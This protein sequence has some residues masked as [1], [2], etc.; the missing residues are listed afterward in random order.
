M[1][2]S[3]KYFLLL[4]KEIVVGQTLEHKLKKV[5]NNLSKD[6][7][8]FL[9]SD[10][11]RDDI[12]VDK[13]DLEAD[14]N[15]TITTIYDNKNRKYK[16][17]KLLQM[18]GYDFNKINTR[19]LEDIVLHL[20]KTQDELVL[21]KGED[22]RKVYLEDNYEDGKGDL[23]TSCMRYEKC[24]KYLDLYVEN[25]DVCSCL[26]L[27]NDEGKVRGRA[28]LQELTNGD[29]YMDRI[30]L[31]NKEYQPIFLNYCEDNAIEYIQNKKDAG[32]DM[33]VRLDN[34]E[35]DYYPYMD[36]F[37]YL[38]DA[39]GCLYSNNA[40]MSSGR[41]LQS[42]GGYYEEVFRCEVSGEL[43]TLYN[44]CYIEA[45]SYCGYYISDMLAVTL[46][47][48]DNCYKDDA[49]QIT[50]GDKANEYVLE[51]SDEQVDCYF[52][53]IGY[54]DD[55]VEITVGSYDGT[56]I[57]KEDAIEL[58]Y[59]KYEYET[60]YAQIDDCIK[61]TYGDYEGKYV[62]EEDAIETKNG[63]EYKENED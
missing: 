18:L 24:Q 20:K 35:F 1:I 30:Y 55:C 47:D 57:L 56:F 6:I 32:E 9:K 2:K 21:V 50:V 29:L 41:Y 10:K 25:P 13:V 12:K 19:E 39:E 27:Y 49:I 37:Y 16:I 31:A 52:D 26:V 11:I 46:L 63:V 61:I 43:L 3:F 59:G 8:N 14:D 45:G 62:L 38:D 44:L 17:G 4:E 5:N 54:R 33:V 51:D 34:Y 58:D 28:L 15:K 36:T 22:I 48:G 40:T 23:N 60:T 53:E 7:L 42:T